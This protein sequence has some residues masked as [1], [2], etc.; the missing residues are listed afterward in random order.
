M[1]LRRLGAEQCAA[2]GHEIR[3]REEVR[4]VD[5][6]VLLLVATG[7][8]HLLRLVV[9]EQP[10]RADRRVR[11]RVHRAQQR[12][13]HVER[14]AGPRREGGRDAEHRAVRVLEDEGRARRVPGGVAAGLERRADAAGREAGGV[15]LASNQV[16]AGELADGGAIAR[17]GVEGVVLLGGRAGQRLEPVRVV[18]G[19]PLHRPRAHGGGDAVGELEIQRLALFERPGE[20]GE[21][22]LREVGALCGLPEHVDAEHLIA[23]HGEV[24]R[25]ELAS[26]GAP[27][28]GREVALGG[29]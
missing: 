24:G 23:R 28:R 8:E 13:L 22:G 15:R 27:L 20:A 6:E 14:L 19:A 12:D 18:R 26:V 1:A 9:A 7:R 10:E 16:L 5:E 3:A 25:P 21:H 4:L 2:G 11:Q 29:G 17:G